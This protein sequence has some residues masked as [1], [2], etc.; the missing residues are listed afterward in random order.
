MGRKSKAT[1]RKKEI[2]QNF[3]QVL[4]EDGYE[5]ASIA[6]IA[7][8]MGVNPSLIIHYF[9]TKEALVVDFVDYILSMYEDAH[10]ERIFSI[11]NPE[12]Q[13]HFFI[14]TLFNPAWYQ[15]IDQGVFYAC[16]YLTSRHPKI[17]ARF[18]DMYHHYNE[19][20]VP[21]VKKWMQAGIIAEDDP[22]TIAEYIMISCTAIG[23]YDKLMDDPEGFKRR[24]SFMQKS[25]L[26]ILR[27]QK[28]TVLA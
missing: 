18:Q 28:K 3:H 12:Q 8:K 16:Y 7:N 2:L 19:L 20:T 15:T 27:P 10:K 9:T 25:I 4:K 26:S 22:R 17:R 1:V 6:K 21:L 11:D 13:F 24:L 14:D 5:N 23:Y